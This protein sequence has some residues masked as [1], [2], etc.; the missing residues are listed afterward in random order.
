[1]ETGFALTV[2]AALVLANALATRVVLRDPYSEQRQKIAQCC[3]VW[4]VPVIGAIVIFALH[5]N[6]EKP[7]GRYRESETGPWDDLTSGRGVSRAVNTHAD[8][9]P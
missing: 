2:L 1:M 8:D 9:A 4:L 7:S 5:R 3:A 6:A